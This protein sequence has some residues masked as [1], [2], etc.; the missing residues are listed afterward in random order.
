M[1]F[2]EYSER[3]AYPQGKFYPNPNIPA[4]TQPSVKQ[5]YIPITRKD[6]K[7]K[8]TCIGVKRIM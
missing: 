6:A 8:V 7:G 1:T 4:Q 3:P 5:V 2:T